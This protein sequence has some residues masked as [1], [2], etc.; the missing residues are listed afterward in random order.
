MRLYTYV[1][2]VYIQLRSLPRAPD[3]PAPLPTWHFH[4]DALQAPQTLGVKGESMDLLS[5][6]TCNSI[7]AHLLPTLNGTPFTQ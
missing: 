5:I 4:L 3:P 6:L 1:V 7:P 2:C